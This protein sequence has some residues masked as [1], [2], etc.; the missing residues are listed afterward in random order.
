MPRPAAANAAAVRAT[1]QLVLGSVGAQ[2]LVALSFGLVARELGRSTFGLLAVLFGIGAI[3]QDCFDFGTSLY[4]TRELAAGRIGAA[5]VV[6]VLRRR[7]IFAFAVGSAVAIAAIAVGVAWPLALSLLVYVVG[8][9]ANGAVYVRLRAAGLFRRVSVLSASERATW[10]VLVCGIVIAKPE[11]DLAV[12]LLVGAM[13]CVY[14]GSTRFGLPR[15]AAAPDESRP[16]L[17]SVY[18]RAASFGVIGLSS[19]LQQLDATLVAPLAGLTA[20]A[21]VGIASKLTGPLTFTAGAITQVA[22]RA[23]AVGDDM[24]RAGA[25]FALRLATGFGLAVAAVA[26]ALPT[27]VVLLLGQDYRHARAAVLVYAAGAAISVVSQPLTAILSAAGNERAVSRVVLTSVVAGLVIG[28]A[29]ASSLGAVGMGL[30]FVV[31]Q[32]AIAAACLIRY[33]RHGLGGC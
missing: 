10:L 12:A 20:A 19:D 21:E 13:G 25:R 6:G 27:L 18:R 15:E 23:V 9:L 26:P 28:A 3:A 7:S 16:T 11:R 33:R 22:F 4:L 31:T 29:T 30:G 1:G 14:F 2:V 17:W 24:S 32:V 5:A 8:A